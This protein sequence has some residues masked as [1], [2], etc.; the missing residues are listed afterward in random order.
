MTGFEKSG[1]KSVQARPS[2]KPR[3]IGCDGLAA[4]EDG[5]RKAIAYR[6]YELY[7][8]RGRDPGHDMEDWFSAERELVKPS[9][10]RIVDAASEVSVRAGV[11]GFVASELQLGVSPRRLIVWGE[12][13]NPGDSKV[14]HMID[15]IDLPEAVDPAGAAAEVRDGVLEFSAPKDPSSGK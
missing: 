9:D 8:S 10:V 7:E 15:E 6:A 12:K 14:V 1:G 2:G 13:V 11:F 5:I 4:L 3:I